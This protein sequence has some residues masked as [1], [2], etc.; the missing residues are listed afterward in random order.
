GL[1][2]GIRAADDVNSFATTGDGFGGAAAVIDSGAPE[3]VDA[4]DVKSAPLN[5][6]GQEQ[7][8][9][10]DFGAIGKFYEAIGAIDVEADNVLRRKNFNAKTAG[11]GDGPEGQVGAGKSRGK[12]EIVFDAGAEASL[13]TGSFALDHN[14]AKTLGSTI[15]R[16]GEP[17][18]S[19]TDDGEVVEIC[20][21]MRAQ[22]NFVGHCGQRRLGQ[23]GA[24]G[25]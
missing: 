6:H 16:S 10:G 9:A 1:A 21:R 14:R 15:N 22:A 24:I 19:T 20:E 12:A 25:E 8:V 5:A 13:S 11:L 2:G 3:A 4:G 7:S 17:G 18:W 23:P